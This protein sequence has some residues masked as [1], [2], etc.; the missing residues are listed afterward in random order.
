M[1]TSFKED[2]R[3]HQDDIATAMDMIRLSL[4][5]IS[6]EN[7]YVDK[8][9]SIIS[10]LADQLEGFSRIPQFS[11]EILG[12]LS[13]WIVMFTNSDLLLNIILERALNG[14]IILGH[15]EINKMRETMEFKERRIGICGERLYDRILFCGVE[16]ILFVLMECLK[17]DLDEN[18]RKVI[19]SM[20]H[21]FYLL[22]LINKENNSSILS[23]LPAKD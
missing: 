21:W 9:V 22:G 14:E 20:L 5:E 13:H 23:L 3:G 8:S 6:Y 16:K 4:P 2:I 19:Y 18:K 12:I 15:T 17:I 11:N 10:S 7:S 1:Q